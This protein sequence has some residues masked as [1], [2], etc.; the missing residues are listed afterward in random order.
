MSN[1][2]ETIKVYDVAGRIP[3]YARSKR[4]RLKARERAGEDEPADDDVEETGVHDL[5]GECS[6]VK[7]PLVEIQLDTAVNHCERSSEWEGRAAS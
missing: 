1:N 3:D 4:R 5:G 7:V 2:D 6:L